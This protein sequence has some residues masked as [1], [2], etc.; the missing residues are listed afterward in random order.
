LQDPAAFATRERIEQ[1]A[2]LRDYY[3]GLQK[4]QLRVKVGKFND[5]LTVNLVGLIV[6]K[7]VSAL[8]GDPADGHGLG[9]TFPSEVTEKDANGKEVTIK[10]PQV[11]WLDKLW[12]ENK[13]D[14]W[15]H[16]NALQGAMTGFPA[17]KIQTD[18]AGGIKLRNLNPLT[19]TIE[20][21]PEDMEKVDL[22]RIL[23]SVQENGK[24]VS[25]K[26]ETKPTDPTAA[27]PSA[28]VIENSRKVGGQKWEILD[29]VIWN[30]DFPPI[31][32]WQNLP[33]LDSPY[34]RSDIE[35]II[36]IQ[37]RLNFVIANLSKITRLYA[38]PQRFG[39]DISPQ[40]ESGELK[41]GPDEMPLFHTDGQGRIDQL[42]PVGDMPALIQFLNSLRD[43]LFSIGREVDTALFK[44]KVG[45]VTNMGLRMMYKDALEKLGTKR[46]LYGQAY[47]ELN[48]RL[49][50][51]GGFEGEI[52]TI[53]WPDPLPVDEVSETTALTSD[54]NNGLV[55]K[56]TASEIRGYDWEQVQERL[57]QEQANSTN[58]GAV[59]LNQ[60]F[61]GG[62]TQNNVKVVPP[63]NQGAQ[64]AIPK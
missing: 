18:G 28:W 43:Y 52:C 7:A 54:L 49:L 42:D 46:M 26:E 24:E 17:V 16:N 14:S 19:L 25:H 30:Y 56:Q 55:D 58:A 13:R 64:N 41:A 15:L 35:G 61:K 37:D 59:L 44:D 10:P 3:D 1:I 11:Q 31:L 57:T 29:S 20:T 39:F 47:Q 62:G 8:V 48:R 50:I 23:Y 45:A 4:S 27:Q 38:A 36:P 60:F 21:A 34:G 63:V 32:T 33:V 12:D 40:M 2:Q 6:D 53:N 9:W 22:Y 5:N 51:L